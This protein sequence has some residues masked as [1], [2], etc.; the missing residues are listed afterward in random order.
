MNMGESLN[1]EKLAIVYVVP[2]MVRGGVGCVP[3]SGG[4]EV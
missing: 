2:S 4:R 3:S 1:V